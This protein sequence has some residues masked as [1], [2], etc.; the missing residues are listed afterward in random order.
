MDKLGKHAKDKV[1][2]FSG[3][4]IG[5]ITYL[6][7]CTQYGIAPAST[8]GKVNDTYWF[9]EGRVEILGKGVSKE[10]VVVEK[11]G[12]VNKDCPRMVNRDCP[13]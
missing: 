12:G 2:G 4:I 5:K 10:E 9:D 7:G 8:E 11:P 1:T 3:I 6:F 13:K